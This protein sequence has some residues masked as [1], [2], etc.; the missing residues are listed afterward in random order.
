MTDQE[1]IARA[2][3]MQKYAYVPYSRFPVGAALECDD[4]TVYTGC[5]VENASYGACICAERTALVKAISDGRRSGFTRIAIAGNSD[6]FC[7]PCGICRQSSLP[8]WKSW[9]QMPMA[10]S[11]A[12]LCG[13]CCRKVLAPTPWKIHRMADSRRPCRNVQIFYDCARSSRA[14]LNRSISSASAF[15]P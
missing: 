4:G 1:L 3:E 14:F 13:N 10:A 9:W 8:I 11:A 12:I 6:G 2:K 5:N 7:Q 15:L